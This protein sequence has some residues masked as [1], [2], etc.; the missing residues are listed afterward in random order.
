MNAGMLTTAAS[1]HQVIPSHLE[2]KAAIA[3]AEPGTHYFCV[4]ENPLPALAYPKLH[5]HPPFALVR[6]VHYSPREHCI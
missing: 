2:W 3:P 5:L 1:I 6:Y 4:L